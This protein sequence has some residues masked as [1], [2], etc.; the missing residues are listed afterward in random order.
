MTK[1]RVLTVI[2]II[3][4][5]ILACIWLIRLFSPRQ[6]DDLSPE[7][8]C[9]QDLIEKSSVLYIIPKFNGWSLSK[10][11][12]ERILVLNKTIAMHGVTHEY[13]E[14]L[15]PKNSSYIEQG[16]EIF[17]GCFNLTATSFKP[18]QLKISQENKK[19]VRKY[20]NLDLWLNQ[21]F[22]KVYHC[23]DSGLLPNWLVDII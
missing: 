12:C 22:H 8:P 18:P 11:F 19:L 13:Q 4:V 5:V 7:I 17:L 14:F 6:L 2:G 21:I 9:S 10:E 3:L 20:M 15:K 23:G 1:S 16:Q